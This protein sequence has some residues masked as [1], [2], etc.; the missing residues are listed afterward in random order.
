MT[1]LPPGFDSKTTAAGEAIAT[2]DVEP[3]ALADGNESQAPDAFGKN[4]P[5]HDLTAGVRSVLSVAVNGWS[6]ITCHPVSVP[7]ILVKNVRLR[8]F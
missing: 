2:A 4:T 8:E 6:F 3:P 5:P 1:T 7:T